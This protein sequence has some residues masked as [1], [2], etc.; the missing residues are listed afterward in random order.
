M[1]SSWPSVKAAGA[2]SLLIRRF[3]VCSRGW[4]GKEQLFQRIPIKSSVQLSKDH[5]MR[6][7]G[8]PG[9]MKDLD[10]TQHHDRSWRRGVQSFVYPSLQL[11]Y[12]HTGSKLASGIFSFK[13][14][15]PLGLIPWIPWGLVNWRSSGGGWEWME[16]EREERN[17]KKSFFYRPSKTNKNPTTR[18]CW[19]S[20]IFIM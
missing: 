2:P 17:R 5:T 16:W 10:K 12:P 1:Y 3:L 6:S 9:I 20:S 11:T 4:R 19:F 7:Q 18:F 8:D 14:W 15:D 13:L